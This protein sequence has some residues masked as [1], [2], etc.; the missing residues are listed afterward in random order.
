MIY[1]GVLLGIPILAFGGVY[2]FAPSAGRAFTNW[3][4]NSKV[5]AVVLTIIAWMWTSC[6]IA[7]SNNIFVPFAFVFNHFWV[8]VPVLVYLTIIWMPNNLPVRALAAILMLFP[9]LMFRTTRLLVPEGGFAPIH[10]F[11]VTAYLAA[12]VGMYGMLKPSHIEKAL[13][14]ATRTDGLARSVGVLFTVMGILL[15]ITGILV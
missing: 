12:I 14:F 6:E 1:W 9:A 7:T 8:L 2:V 5:V 15:A 3:F 4:E 11:V 10:L 13:A